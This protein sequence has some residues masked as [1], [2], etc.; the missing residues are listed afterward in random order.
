MSKQTYNIGIL[1]IATGRYITLWKEFY[2]S[3]ELHFLRDCRKHYFIFTDSPKIYASDME[4]V[5]IFRQEKLGW[6]YDTLMR[7]DIFLKAEKQLQQMDYLYFFNANMQFIAP[8]ERKDFFLGRSGQELLGVIHPGFWDKSPHEFTYDRNPNSRACMAL[9]EGER[10]YMGS[11]N[12]GSSQAFL[13]LIHELASRTHE[14]LKDEVIALWHDESHL[15]RYF[16]EHRERVCFVSKEYATPEEWVGGFVKKILY[17]YFLRRRG[18][19]IVLRNKANPLYG[20][21]KW[22][23]GE[24]DTRA[25]YSVRDRLYLLGRKVVNTLGLK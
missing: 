16:W 24:T 13:E 5:H 12:G 10:Y 17:E 9:D 8:I 14:D 15:N 25:K 20:G 18:V 23:R 22:M 3:A 21:H 2:K 7:F 11:L 6:P 4:S 1:Y 19:K